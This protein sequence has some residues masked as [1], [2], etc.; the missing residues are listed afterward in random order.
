MERKLAGGEF[1]YSVIIDNVALARG[2]KRQVSDTAELPLALYRKLVIFLTYAGKSMSEMR[3]YEVGWKTQFAV[4]V[5]F[6]IEAA[7]VL[8]AV[9]FLGGKAIIEWGK[10][11]EDER[12]E[13]FSI[14]DL[15]M[16]WCMSVISDFTNRRINVSKRFKDA[17]QKL[18]QLVRDFVHYIED[19][20]RDFFYQADDSAKGYRIFDALRPELHIEVVREFKDNITRGAVVSIATRYEEF[21]KRS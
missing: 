15:Y 10:L 1:A 7:R 17:R 16:A 3:F 11:F 14:W 12:T 19:L 18:D 6:V 5:P 20:E 21:L 13:H 2:H 9:I 8:F 4:I